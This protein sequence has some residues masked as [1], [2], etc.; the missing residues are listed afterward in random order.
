MT[1]RFPIILDTS[2]GNR[3]KELPA[4]DNLD[5][6]GSG[7]K[8]AQTIE[9]SSLE[10]GTIT[11]NNTSFSDVA[12]SG[13]YDDLTDTPTLFDKDYNALSNKPFIPSVIG[14]LANV[15]AHTPDDG[16]VII[17][18]S[19]ENRFTFEDKFTEIDLANFNLAD[20]GDVVFSGPVTDKFIKFYAG[21][22]RESSVTWTDV[23]NKPTN[24]SYL[25]N[26]AGYVTQQDLESGIEI[27]A[28]GDLTGSVF[29]D[30]STLLVDGVNGTLSYI[31]TNS[32]NWAGTA[33]ETVS[34][35][36]DRIAAALTA[37]GQQA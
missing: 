20:L 37:L 13:S 3:L 32:S 5:L 27:A 15:A 14:D 11:V 26:D 9:V 21:G 7:I 23:I 12:F 8:N 28:T 16:Q 30:D 35:A 19:S 36:L 31:P 10:T 33:P 34:E 6:Q 29:S 4:G 1:N 24:V 25:T 17:W 2:D 18:R 22:W